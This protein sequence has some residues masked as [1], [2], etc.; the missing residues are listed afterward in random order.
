MSTTSRR[1]SS[2]S[3]TTRIVSPDDSCTELGGYMKAVRIYHAMTRVTAADLAASS[4]SRESTDCS[5]ARVD[6][7]GRFVPHR[8]RL[9]PGCPP[10]TN[11]LVG[12]QAFD[13]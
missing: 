11:Y 10:L 5:T 13:R 12:L 1:T 4:S 7:A 8:R 6:G 2:V 9:Q 3:S